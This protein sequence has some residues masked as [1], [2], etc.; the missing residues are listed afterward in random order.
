MVGTYKPKIA[1]YTIA[2]NEDK[3]VKRWYDNSKDADYHIIADTGSIDHTVEIAKQ[4]G[5]I[6]HQIKV[7]PFRFDDARNAALALVPDDVDICVSLDMDEVPEKDFFK[8]LRKVWKEDTERAWVWWDTGQRWKNNNRVHARFGYRWIKP[9]HEVT[10]KYADGPEK[11]VDTDL[12]VYHKPDDTKARTYYL[13]MLEAAVH[14]DPRDARMW[15]YLVR[16]HFF[17]KNWHAVIENAHK[18]LQA[19]GWYVERAAI[20]RA[21]GHASSILGKKEEALQW[22]ARGTKEAPDQLEAWFS[23]AQFCYEVQNWQGCW[24]AASKRFE[25]ERTH[26]YLEDASVWNWRCYDLLA[27]SGYR[28]GK[29]EDAIRYAK[30]AVEANPTDGRLQDNLKWLEENVTAQD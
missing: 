13:P 9:C 12:L 24:D 21:A 4:L 29:H 19:G 14:E 16:E 11:S 3:H 18:G 30:M 1:V 25:L 10:F 15:H 7:Q 17:H 5:I 6:V 2:L 20:C 8:K 22:F 23:L 27:I 26:H 28:T